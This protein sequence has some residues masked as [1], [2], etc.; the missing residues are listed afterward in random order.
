MDKDVKYW[1]GVY[2]DYSKGIKIAQLCLSV[3]CLSCESLAN[4]GCLTFHHG[5]RK[6]AIAHAKLFADEY[7]CTLLELNLE[8]YREIKIK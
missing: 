5:S 8:K 1:Y 4:P 6:K 7:G 2:K 3:D